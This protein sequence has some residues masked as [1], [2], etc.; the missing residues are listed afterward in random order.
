MGTAYTPAR[1]RGIVA[2]DQNL[3]IWRQ[4]T[5][6][7]DA[8]GSNIG[9]IGEMNPRTGVSQPAAPTDMALRMSGAQTADLDVVCNRAGLPVLDEAGLLWKKVADSESKLRGRDL[10]VPSAAWQHIDSTNQRYH[11]HAVTLPDD[12]IVM[13]YQDSSGV[14]YSRTFDPDLL[15][16]S[17]EVTVD[18]STEAN[19]FPCLVVIPRVNGYRLMLY[20]WGTSG[21]TFQIRQFYSDDQGATWEN[22]GWC[23]QDAVSSATISNRRRIRGAYLN[24]QVV[25]FGHVQ[26][27]TTGQVSRDRIIQWASSD[28]GLNF[29]QVVYSDGT[30]WDNA[31]AWID[32]ATWRGEFVLARLVYD[33]ASTSAVP[34]FRRLASAWY[35]WTS[36]TDTSSP[37]ALTSAQHW[38][39]YTDP[40]AGINTYI[41]EGELA[42]VTADDKALYAFGRHAA[43]GDDGAHPVIRSADGAESWTVMGQHSTY[44]GNGS[45]WWNAGSPGNF[46]APDNELWNFTGCYQRGRVCMVTSW[47]RATTVQNHTGAVW[48]GG[49]QTTT[50]PS[51]VDSM[52]PTKRVAWSHTGCGMHLASETI[53]TVATAGGATETLAGGRVTHTN[54][55][56]MPTAVTVDYVPTTTAAEGLITEWGLQ[57]VS[58]AGTVNLDM[59]SSS[60][61]PINYY[62]RVVVTQSTIRLYDVNAGGYVGA[63]VNYTAKAPIR[64][65]IAMEGSSAKVWYREGTTSI[66]TTNDWA[67]EDRNWEEVDDTNSLTGAAANPG[68]LIRWQ[69]SGA[70][71]EVDWDE[72]LFTA[73][74]YTGIGLYSQPKRRKYPGCV[75]ESPSWL[76]YS[77]LASGT[78]GPAMQGDEWTV[79]G[80]ADY[81]YEALLPSVSPSPRHPWRSPFYIAEP[82]TADNV[83]LSFKRGAA[84]ERSESTRWAVLLD[85]MNMGGVEIY[86]YYGGAWNL[87]GTV[88]YWT[89][90]FS[91]TAEVFEVTSG[92]ALNTAVLRRNE[93]AG[94]LVEE[95]N[96]GTSVARARVLS[97]TPGAMNTGAGTSLPLRIRVDNGGSFGANPT[98]RIYPR[99]ALLVLDLESL[100]QDIRGIQIRFPFNHP[101]VGAV[102]SPGWPLEG[103]AEIATMAA[104]PLWAWGWSPSHGRRLTTAVDVELNEAED[105]TGIPYQRKPARRVLEWTWAEGVPMHDAMQQPDPDYIIAATGDDPIAFRRDAPNETSDQLRALN[106][107]LP[108]VVVCPRIDSGDSG[109]P[110]HWANGAFLARITSTVDLDN[111]TGDEEWDQVDRVQSLVF[112]EVI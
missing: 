56:A 55:P 65:R 26:C 78:T 48:L 22:G 36:G 28:G 66:P 92:G 23:L 6:I 69:T 84:D 20:R 8:G 31:G 44:A 60:A 4:E 73:G 90:T 40:G 88:G 18:S 30:D 86:L 5:G 33:S 85:G 95:Y 83:R 111:V 38:G 41:G 49:W 75:I 105:G 107:A 52:Q 3:E 11:R 96:A 2:P 108:P 100:S 53:W 93:L 94:C 25:L 104:G 27:T 81:P 54:G 29:T 97:N 57:F 99:R 46:T 21:S 70:N 1:F 62:I 80:T 91:R 98:L 16:W 82:A 63:A 19:A 110:D 64:I 87:A 109:R 76:G 74:S 61:T 37:A 17:S 50:M 42:I 101:I 34:A 71:A 24:G 77:A 59:R 68:D 12:S 67:F 79:Y 45:V 58:T 112:E 51:L 7:Y 9:D 15:S 103:Y 106:G 39:A 14:T 89:G 43:G 10:P 47:R 72:W 13:C 102:A 32:V 35:P